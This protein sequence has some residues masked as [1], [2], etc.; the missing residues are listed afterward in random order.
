M[1]I[2]IGG[3]TIVKTAGITLNTALVFNASGQ[4]T[5]NPI[6]GYSGAQS[7]GA[8]YYSTVTGGVT[9]SVTWPSG[10]ATATVVFTC[11]VAGIYAMGYSGIHRGGSGVPAGKNTYGYSCFAKNGVLDY[12][13]HWNQGASY[14]NSWHGGGHSV[15]FQC[16]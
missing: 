2:D 15:L 3:V 13:D 10:L 5:A 11:P 14:N 8:N 16:A 6:P 4:G 12:H 1:G 9:N 7:G